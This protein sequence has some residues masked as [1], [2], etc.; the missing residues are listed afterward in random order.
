MGAPEV[1]P[2]ADTQGA[3]AFIARY[4]GAGVALADIPDEAVLGPVDLDQVLE[5]PS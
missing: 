4:G 1:V 3:E 2:F 5:T